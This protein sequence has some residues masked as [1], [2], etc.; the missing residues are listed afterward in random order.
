MKNAKKRLRERRRCPFEGAP[1]V[2]RAG[3][4]AFEPPTVSPPARRTCRGKV[5]CVPNAMS[6][7]ATGLFTDEANLTGGIS[8]RAN[9]A[10][11]LTR[12]RKKLHGRTR[13]EP[14]N[15]DSSG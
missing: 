5:W 11:R 4:Y 10:A 1:S 8:R 6:T 9:A 12:E 13:S 3:T 2:S 7:S 15:P 14:R